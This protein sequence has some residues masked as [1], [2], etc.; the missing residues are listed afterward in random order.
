[1][2]AAGL[3]TQDLSPVKSN[4][5]TAQNDV[6]LL[7]LFLSAVSLAPDNL[8]IDDANIIFFVSG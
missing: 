6:T 5:K 8:P 1:M 7:Q 3:L 4:I 2:S